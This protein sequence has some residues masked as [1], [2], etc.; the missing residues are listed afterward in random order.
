M[1]SEDI[2]NLRK[3]IQSLAINIQ[4]MYFNNRSDKNKKAKYLLIANLFQRLLKLNTE[5]EINTFLTTIIAEYSTVR[6]EYDIKFGE[7]K[8]SNNNALIPDVNILGHKVNTYSQ[9]INIIKGSLKNAK[10]KKDDK[11][12]E[13]T[14]EEKPIEVKKEEKPAVPKKEVKPVVEPKKEEKP[15]VKKEA[16]TKREI[17]PEELLS[18]IT[19]Q[20]N[21]IIELSN[22]LKKLDENTTEAKSISKELY[23]LKLQRETDIYQ[24]SSSSYIRQIGELESML[25]LMDIFKN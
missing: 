25:M 23:D 8:T 13:T 7:F 2:L 6:S 18:S 24:Y 14:P 17:K 3:E 15:P 10:N 16:K 9:V 19:K 20:S 12:E 22:R 5:E 11:I 4:E 1:S 21:K